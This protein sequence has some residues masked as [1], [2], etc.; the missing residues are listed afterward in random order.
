MM[1]RKLTDTGVLWSIILVLT[2]TACRREKVILDKNQFTSLLIDMH[3]ADGT[4]GAR[5]GWRD[6]DEKRNYAY[7]N[8]VFKRYGIDRTQFD[9]CMYYY[10]AQTALFSK[11][12]DVV[13]DSLNKRLTVQNVIMNE[14][15]AND[16][17]NLYPYPD[18][19]VF[20]TACRVKIAELD[21]ITSG[22]Y[23]FATT[24]KLDSVDKSKNNRIEA[25]F[26]SA[27]DED[28]LKVREVTVFWDTL[29]HTYNWSQYVDTNYTK[30]VIK[31]IESDKG[32]PL[33]YRRGQ[34]WGTTLFKVYSPRST[35]EH[36]LETP[37]RAKENPNKEQMPELYKNQIKIPKEVIRR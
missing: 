15:R 8:D 6:N 21:S 28:T 33:K 7:Y 1:L 12:Y 4:L 24:I 27:N 22:L 37:L 25:S 14:L 5:S 17:I 30:L 20:D 19:I 34:A 16:S 29:A 13:I 32:K 3:L 26:Y 11:I 36:V 10:S 9:S 18:T 2:L 23:K 35:G 31:F